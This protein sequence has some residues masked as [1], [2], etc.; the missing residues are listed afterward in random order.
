MPA[1]DANRTAEHPLESDLVFESIAL[2][3]AP[4]ARYLAA[5]ELPVRVDPA[6]PEKFH[7]VDIS[8]LQQ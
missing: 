6:N 3:E 7:K 1:P 5:G 2:G 4:R 8:S